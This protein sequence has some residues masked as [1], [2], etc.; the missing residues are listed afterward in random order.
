M[1]L[2]LKW[3]NAQGIHKWSVPQINTIP[4]GVQ[5]VSVIV[6]ILITSLCMIYPLWIM[7][8]IVQGCTLFAIIC[9][10][11]W[12]IPQGLHCKNSHPHQ[13]PREEADIGLQFSV[14]IC[15]VSRQ[16]SRLF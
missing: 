15:L 11:I 14:T 9:L 1:A 6:T 12:N 8:T 16:L 13:V 7:M 10:L 3:E 5:G 2:W 4:T